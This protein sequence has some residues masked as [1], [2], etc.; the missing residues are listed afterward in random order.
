M[1]PFYHKQHSYVKHGGNYV[2]INDMYKNDDFK[3]FIADSLDWSAFNRRASPED[4][5][6]QLQEF[7]EKNQLIYGGFKPN[8]KLIVLDEDY[9]HL[10]RNISFPKYGITI[11]DYLY[12]GQKRQYNITSFPPD[13]ITMQR[14][15]FAC[16]KLSRKLPHIIVN[17]KKD[18][19]LYLTDTMNL[20]QAEHLE[21]EGDFSS[22]FDLYV[23]PGYH[24]DAL[25]I[26][27]PDLMADLVDARDSFDYEVIDDRLYIYT[28]RAVADNP[29]ATI[30]K[31][32]DTSEILIRKFDSQAK[33]YSDPRAG[34]MKHKMVAFQG[35]RLKKNTLAK[36]LGN[37]SNNRFIA[38]IGALVLFA[39]MAIC[40]AIFFPPL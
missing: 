25:Q 12:D 11:G 14:L 19:S 7:C 32:L 28:L 24:L 27:T 38:L 22:Y 5:H 34:E 40:N 23:P 26:I 31:L 1:T 15:G 8:S 35:W 2:I 16:I 33:R 30:R 37:A 36:T 17:S 13:D 39:I 3:P 4:R 10:D 21:L 6:A 9:G 29:E 20:Y 18:H